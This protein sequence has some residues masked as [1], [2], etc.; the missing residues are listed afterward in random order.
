MTRGARHNG[1]ARAFPQPTLMSPSPDLRID[2]Q[3]DG[4][5]W[6]T[7]ERPGVHNA[8]SRPA[9]AA[10][11]DAVRALARRPDVRCVGLRGAGRA[12]FAAGGDLVDLADVRTEAST[13][14]MVDDCTAALDAI[15]SCPLPVIAYLNGDA[16]GGG[17]ELAVACD[18]RMAAPHAHIAYIHGRMAITSAWGGGSDLCELVG[19]AKAMRMMSRCERVDAPTALAWGLV[20]A[21]VGDDAA[22][23]AF[24]EPM[25]ALPPQVLRGIKAQTRA[26]RNGEALDARRAI[27]RE[28]LV[29]TWLGDAHWAAVERFLAKDRE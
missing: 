7:I 20:D 28:Q 8:L 15:R 14:R 23:R 13:R 1:A 18:L 26:W 9:L 22:M 3:D 4:L 27:E 16:L 21:I 29:T 25:L 2:T 11:A 24:V 17:A 12:Y 19:S 10:L 5:A 6:I